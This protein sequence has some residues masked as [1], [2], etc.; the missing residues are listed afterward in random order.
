MVLDGELF[1]VYFWMDF[2]IVQFGVMCVCL[3]LAGLLGAS[4]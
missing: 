4:F 2:Q 1:C 3:H